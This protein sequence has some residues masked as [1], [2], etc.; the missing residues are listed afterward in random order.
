MATAQALPQANTATSSTVIALR[1]LS[2]IR[3][4]TPL[5]L[6]AVKG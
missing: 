5:F 6:S 2:N 1:I 4:N 3:L